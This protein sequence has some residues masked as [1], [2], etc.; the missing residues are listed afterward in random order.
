MC[1]SV[2]KFIIVTVSYQHAYSFLFEGASEESTSSTRS[3]ITSSQSVGNFKTVKLQKIAGTWS[4]RMVSTDPYTLKVIGETSFT[5][6]LWSQNKH[7]SRVSLITYLRVN[8][9]HSVP[10]HHFGFQR[11]CFSLNFSSKLQ[12]FKNLKSSYTLLF[13]S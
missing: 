11:V 10:L 3:L 4:I 8:I 5:D 12:Q 2:T 13:L 1:L 6:S 9:L 7:Q